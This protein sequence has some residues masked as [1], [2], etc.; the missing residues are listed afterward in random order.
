ME[1]A[2]DMRRR[3]EAYLKAKFPQREEL[4]VVEMDQ[5][6]AGGFP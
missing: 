1:K 3:L 6:T 2:Q 4:S 5:L